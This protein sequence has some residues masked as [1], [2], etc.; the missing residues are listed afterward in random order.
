M[1]QGEGVGAL[2][3]LRLTGSSVMR[4]GPGRRATCARARRVLK[5]LGVL[6][7][8]LLPRCSPL[9]HSRLG[10]LGK[11]KTMSSVLDPEA[12][13]SPGFPLVEVRLSHDHSD[14]CRPSKVTPLPA[15]GPRAARCW[16]G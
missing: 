10:K 4:T 8:M 12:C 13:P 2:L 15:P 11:L 5:A 7:F 3:T 1:P 6:V 9:A 16:A 14:V